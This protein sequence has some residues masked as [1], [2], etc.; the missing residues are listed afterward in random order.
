[1][2]KQFTVTSI[3][4]VILGLALGFASLS[5]SSGAQSKKSSEKMGPIPDKAYVQ[6]IWDTWAT[7]DPAQ[8]AQFHAQGPNVFYDESPLKYNSWAEFQSGVTKILDTIKSGTFTVNDD[9]MLHPAGDYVWGTATVKEDLVMKD[10][11]RDM[12]TLRWTVVFQKQDGKWLIV[13]EHISAPAE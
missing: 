3:C 11:K 7:L 6:K 4:L 1:M 10:G 8:E 12:A 2:R 13:H 5:L 9:L